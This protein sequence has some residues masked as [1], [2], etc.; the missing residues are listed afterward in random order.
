M[1]IVLSA[2]FLCSA[3]WGTQAVA[4][5]AH[6]SEDIVKYF[7]ESVELGASR[8]ICVGTEEECAKAGEPAPKTG[9]DMLVNFELD[10]AELTADAR[11]QLAEFAR[12]LKDNRLKAHSFVIEGHTDARGSERYNLG[13][14]ERRADSVAGFLLANGIEPARLTAVGKGMDNPRVADRYDPVNRRV[15]MRI[16]Q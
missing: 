13:L 5:S 1:R 10:S 9:L 16:S 7:A 2:V 14:S 15:E 12:A 6:S 8:G 3:L 4:Q 11:S